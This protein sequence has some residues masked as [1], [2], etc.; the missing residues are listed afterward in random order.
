MICH[1]IVIIF[2]KYFLLKSV[3]DSKSC[4]CFTKVTYDQAKHTL[5]E[6]SNQLGESSNM[7]P[8]SPMNS[9]LEDLS[10]WSPSKFI[11]FD[12][13]DAHNLESLNNWSI[14]APEPGVVSIHHL[15][16]PT[17]PIDRQLHEIRSFT[18]DHGHIEPGISKNFDDHFQIPIMEQRIENVYTTSN[19][20]IP[21][22]DRYLIAET[23]TQPIQSIVGNEGI[24]E[25]NPN[26]HIEDVQVSGSGMLSKKRKISS[27]GSDDHCRKTKPFLNPTENTK[28]HSKKSSSQIQ[29]SPS[30]N[31]NFSRSGIEQIVSTKNS[32]TSQVKIP[33]SYARIALRSLKI[34]AKS[35]VEN[36]SALYLLMQKSCKKLK[37]EVILILGKDS[38]ENSQ[39]AKQLTVAINRAY[40][41]LAMIVCGVIL[42]KKEITQEQVGPT[43]TNTEILYTAFEF[44]NG[45]FEGL[46]NVSQKEMDSVFSTWPFSDRYVWQNHQELL[47][48]LVRYGTNNVF[49]PPIIIGL[50]NKW[51]ESNPPKEYKLDDLSDFKTLLREVY[52]KYGKLQTFSG[53]KFMSIGFKGDGLE[54]HKTHLVERFLI[55]KGKNIINLNQGL[56]RYIDFNF[57]RIKTAA[58]ENF[59]NNLHFFES[60]NEDYPNNLHVQRA[61]EL[62][63]T[64]KVF[65]LIEEG[66]TPAFVKALH[67]ICSDYMQ[68]DAMNIVLKNCIDF[69]LTQVSEWSKLHFNQCNTS[70][71]DTP[72]QNQFSKFHKNQ[73]ILQYLINFDQCHVI[74]VKVILH[75]IEE[76]FKNALPFIQ[77]EIGISI[78]ENPFKSRTMFNKRIMEEL[79]GR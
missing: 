10:M 11:D 20:P 38:P 23:I 29:F 36:N 55:E 24:H 49:S 53:K 68:E 8:A 7:P 58:I 34:I 79:N 51:N 48:A 13:F 78:T 30:S 71:N 3:I 6:T 44:F 77:R 62:E 73:S 32:L 72:K 64:H 66:L 54:T 56:V 52:V 21:E 40:Q 61:I 75:L 9:C 17:S 45:Y 18:A 28:S 14:L 67:T 33:R 47:H 69:M 2:M 41:D 35:R 59:Q 1:Y 74:P 22:T 43:E 16:S 19:L 31:K 15:E 65:K 12:S 46:K 39:K 26:S 27:K 37:D 60:N 70:L 4:T 25:N 42:T 50:I 63:L 5:E 76:W 57:Q